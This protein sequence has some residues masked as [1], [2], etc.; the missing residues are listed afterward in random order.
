MAALGVAV[1]AFGSGAAQ[2]AKAP[3]TRVMLSPNG[4]GKDGTLV[5]GRVLDTSGPF[6]QS[7]GTNGRSC[8][9][10]HDPAAG[11]S[12]TPSLARARFDATDGLDPLFRPHDGADTPNADVSTVASR[13]SAYGMLLT[14]GLLRIGIPL[15]A[16]AEFELAA[17]DDPYGYASASEL[18]LFRRPLPTTNLRFQS[19]IMWDG[20]E[21]PHGASLPQ[22]LASQ[23]LNATLGHGQGSTPL[24][25]LTLQAIVSFELAR[26]NAQTHDTVAGPLHQGGGRGG[27]QRLALQAFAL[28]SNDPLQT[29]FEPEVFSLFPKWLRLPN[30]S[31]NRRTMARK[32][33]ARGEQLFNTRTFN[34]FDTPGFNDVANRPIFRATCSTCHNAPN[35]GSH[36]V[37]RLMNIGIGTQILRRT[38]DEPEYTLRN[39]A[40]GE[41]I[42]TQDPGAA[43]V[44]GRWADIGK[45]KVPSLR[46]L[47]ARAPYFHNGTARDLTQVVDFY[48]RRYGIGLRGEEVE[49]LVA[50]LNAL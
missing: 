2:S 34:I 30:R 1:L 24:D 15:P 12:I 4:T 27:P 7:L 21:S 44:S 11:W 47:A 6:F 16:G 25:E 18:S 35:V 8:G 41:M 50:F 37:P 49:D 10:C 9:T 13:R 20:R 31:R 46:G 45:F 28:G 48:D 3:R 42:A 43:L 23:A 39:L 32:A 33:V 26:T 36:S 19:Q 40:S 14:K 38:A 5:P 17:V 29:N 22:S